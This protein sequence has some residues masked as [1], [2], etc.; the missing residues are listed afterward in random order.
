MRRNARV[1]AE[2][3]PGLRLVARVQALAGRG[4]EERPQLGAAERA[5]RRVGDGEVDDEVEPPVPVVSVHRSAAKERHPDAVFYV[6]RQAVRTSAAGDLSEGAPIG[7]RAGGGVEVEAIDPARGR[8]DVEHRVARAV[9][10][11]SVGDRHVAQHGL[12]AAVGVETVEGTRARRLRVRHRAAVEAPL[13]IAA[14]VIH[15]DQRVG[16]DGRQRLFHREVRSEQG[17]P[18]LGREHVT[19]ALTGADRG[20]HAGDLVALNATLGVNGQHGADQHV[21]QQQSIVR[22]VPEWA[23]PVGGAGDSELFGRGA[24]LSQ[25]RR[26]RRSRRGRADRDE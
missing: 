23:L 26:R 13:G 14:A 16:E 9:P 20:G 3:S 6:D 2:D 21:D 18:I 10:L 17:E 15:P 7:E 25:P 24:H 5:G 1:V 12:A 8:I 22:G 19:T 11:Q 4:D